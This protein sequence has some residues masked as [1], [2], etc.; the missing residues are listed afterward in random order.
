MIRPQMLQW[1]VHALIPVLAILIVQHHVAMEEG[2]TPH[3]LPRQPYRVTLLQQRGVSQRLRHAPIQRQL[4]LGHQPPVL[5]DLVH[6]WVELEVL[7]HFTN[8]AREILYG[9][10]RQA[11][12]VVLV[13]L[14]ALERRPI[15]FKRRLEIGQYGLVGVIAAIQCIAAG[16]DQAFS[17]VR[18][19]HTFLDQL[20]GVD[21]ALRGVGVDALVHQRL[22]HHGLVLLVVAEAAVTHEVDNR[23]L[24][25][26]HTVIK[27]DFSHKTNRFGVITI[28]MEDGHF[29]HLAHV[30]A[31]QRGA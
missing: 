6:T 8:L 10:H 15:D 17:F 27:R 4:A 22:R 25:K 1:N 23:V 24:V 11:R 19:D 12:V 31:I 28:D 26:L 18:L 7:R 5:H 3:I 9:L 2:A 29:Q 20:F 13:P 14:R 21:L 30:G 16:A